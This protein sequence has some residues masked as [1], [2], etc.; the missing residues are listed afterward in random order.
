MSKIIQCPLCEK[1][2]SSIAEHCP[3]CGHPDPG[4]RK[5][6]SKRIRSILGVVI[7]ISAL[8][9]GWFVAIP[10]LQE[11]WRQLTDQRR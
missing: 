6:R 7:F 5:T 9:Y 3:A 8:T 11:Q 10:Q 4:G 2:C 1:N